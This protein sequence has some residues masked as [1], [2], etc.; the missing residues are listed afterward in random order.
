M[1]PTRTFANR[2][3][4]LALLLCCLLSLPAL[5][6]QISPGNVSPPSQSPSA[7]TQV[8]TT[9]TTTTPPTRA[10]VAETYG[11]IE[12]SFEAN[13][14]QTAP[15]VNFL[16]RGAGYTLF[17]RPTEAVFVMSRPGGTD[18]RPAVRPV[19]TDQRETQLADA[20]SAAPQG[21]AKATSAVLRMKLVGA[22]TTAQVEAADELAGQTNYFIGNDPAKWRTGIPTFRRV[23]YRDVYPG[24]ELTYYG[25]QRQLEYDFIVAPGRDPRAVRLAFAGADKVAVDANGDLL[26]SVGE[27]VLRQRKP[28]VYQEIAGARRIVEGGYAVSANGQVGFAVGAYDKRLPLVIDPT[29]VYSTYIGGGGGDQALDLALDPAG[30]A[31][32]TGFTNSTNFPTANPVQSANA[33]EQDVFVTKI[34]AAGSAIVYSTY[35]GGNSID[36]AR[37]IAA[38]AAGNAYITGF[39][40]STS[41]PIVNAVQA[42][43]NNS[44]DAFVTK[45]NPTGS[46]LVYSTYLGGSESAEFGEGIAVDADGNVYTTGI[47]FSDNFPVVNAAQG[48]S[49]GTEDA[50]ITKINAAGSAFVYS[51]YV[52]G[53]DI[54]G[55]KDITVDGT[56]NAYIIGFTN[57]NDFPT[58]NPAQGTNGGGQDAFVT[59]LNAAGSAFVYSTY[60]G[61]SARDDGQQI[62]V[63][64]AGNAYL[65]GDTESTNFPLANAVQGT[66]GGTSVL[67]DAYVTKLNAAGSAFVYSTYLGGSGG[68]I[69]FS[70]AV[71]AA[72]EAYVAGATSSLNTFPVANAIQCARNGDVDVFVTKFNAAGS[73][74]IYSTYLGGSGHEQG[75]GIALDSTGNAYVGGFTRSDN[76]P[77]VNPIQSTFGGDNIFGDAFVLKLND[78]LGPNACATPIPTP[79]PTPTPTPIPTPTAPLTVQFTGDNIPVTENAGR[80]DISVTLS[81]P[82]PTAVTVD[83]ATSPDTTFLGCDIVTS[84]ASERCDFTTTLGTLRFAPGEQ[85][86]AFHI[87]LTD[88]AYPDGT[89]VFSVAL[90]NPTG[91]ATL[92]TPSST[93]ISISDNDTNPAA[94]NPIDAARFFVQQHYIDFLNRQGEAAGVN[95]WVNQLDTCPPGGQTCD[96]VAT[97][98]SFFRSEEFMLKGNFVIRFYKVSLATN[99]RYREFTR[100]SQRVTGQTSAEVVANR[101]AFANE[102]VAR[103][104]V[105]AMYDGLS[106][107]AY[108]DKLEQNAGVTLANK[109]QLVANLNAGTETRAQ[110]LRD[111]VESAEVKA[112]MYNDAFVLMEY[113]GYLRRDPEAAGFTAWLNYLNAHPTEFRTMVNGF[114]NSIEYRKR[115]GRP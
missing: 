51:T 12:M 105:K 86:K 52:G 99:P 27:S 19:Q 97:S 80:L 70:I 47:T 58:V 30:N 84:V 101:E 102:W 46:A 3:L 5:V 113:F 110:V 45:L 10:Q 11:Q 29:L 34:N 64:S 39:S 25:N 79:T 42:T 95:A 72:G 32:I 67:Q 1:T 94:P 88:D 63:D 14:G 73:A 89:E 44:Q 69:G 100:D 61:G 4:H 33:G 16:T 106:N 68:E 2:R 41:F 76:F 54:E 90:S 65:T 104:D 96:R 7:S 87:F 15:A 38:D 21:P 18:T 56:G 98:S 6:R 112:R 62:V 108:V 23:R 77:V 109:A 9:T 85:T 93:L 103:A 66:N 60:L 91:G 82:A 115:F 35:L 78:A 107:Q 40:N 37:G 55:A 81:A 43:D 31:Y 59:K 114:V 28:V 20:L 48:T 74:F 13:R 24:V 50:Y 53:S 49:G 83:Y 71:N 8:R 26:L 17:L 75:R 92:G 36:Q 22:Q 57:S 111:V